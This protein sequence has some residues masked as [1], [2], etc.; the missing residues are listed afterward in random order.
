M[1][2][3]GK[4]G[5]LKTYEWN[6]FKFSWIAHYRKMRKSQVY[7]RGSPCYS[8]SSRGQKIKH[9]TKILSVCILGFIFLWRFSR[10]NWFTHGLYNLTFVHRVML[11]DDLNIHVLQI[12]KWCSPKSDPW[13][14]FLTL[15]VRGPFHGKEFM[16]GNMGEQGNFL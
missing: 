5:T 6:F 7:E 14:F 1:S 4:Y 11:K 15:T 9:I 12:R 3:L 13:F 2:V 16:G 10:K 8:L